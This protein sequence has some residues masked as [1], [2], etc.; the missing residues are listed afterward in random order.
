MQKIL[1]TN[2][3]L[4]LISVP[5]RKTSVSIEKKK[6][7]EMMKSEKTQLTT[8]LNQ[9]EQENTVR[10]QQLQSEQSRIKEYQFNL[11]LLDE[12]N[13]IIISS[14]EKLYIASLVLCRLDQT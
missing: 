14:D 10:E 4:F 13:S 1:A 9:I 2:E 8:K 7:Y 3:G 5:I 11:Q 12:H 6:R